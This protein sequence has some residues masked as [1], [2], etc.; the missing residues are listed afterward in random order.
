MS[1]IISRTPTEPY[2]VVSDLNADIQNVI[3]TG[4]TGIDILTIRSMLY[5]IVTNE[6]WNSID[7]RVENETVTGVSLFIAT[8]DILGNPETWKKKLTLLNVDGTTLP[9]VIGFMAEWRILNNI[10]FV[11]S[12]DELN[13]YINVYGT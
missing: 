2:D 1:V 3:I 12:V 5:L 6:F 9:A 4:V 13:S 7:I 8:T 10:Y 11:A